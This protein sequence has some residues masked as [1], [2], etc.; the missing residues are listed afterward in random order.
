[1]VIIKS[2]III[3]KDNMYSES[4][5]TTSNHF[6]FNDIKVANR[7]KS[8]PNFIVEQNRPIHSIID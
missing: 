5:K 2:S 1:M 3:I 7:P 6:D 4:I 8:S